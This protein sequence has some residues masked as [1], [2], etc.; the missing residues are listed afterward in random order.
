MKESV[1]WTGVAVTIPAQR[2]VTCLSM[3]IKSSEFISAGMLCPN[4]GQNGAYVRFLR[5]VM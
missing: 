4:L 2:Y 5:Y 3:F 1:L